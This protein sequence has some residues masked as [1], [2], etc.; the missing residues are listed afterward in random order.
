MNNDWQYLDILCP[1]GTIINGQFLTPDQ[2]RAS[3][4]DKISVTIVKKVREM[5]EYILEFTLFKNND[6]TVRRIYSI[7]PKYLIDNIPALNV[8]G[9]KILNNLQETIINETNS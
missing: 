7:Y 6:L 1:Q 2:I 8:Y 9:Q 3:N 5:D 4:L